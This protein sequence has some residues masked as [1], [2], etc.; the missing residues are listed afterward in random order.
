MAF[1]R[2]CKIGLLSLKS[3]NL[4]VCT[5]QSAMKNLSWSE[6]KHLMGVSVINCPVT[7]QV[8]RTSSAAFYPFMAFLQAYP[9]G[10]TCM[11]LQLQCPSIVSWVW[12]T[13]PSVTV[14]LW[15]GNCICLA[16]AFSSCL[17][18]GKHLRTI[19]AR[20]V[21]NTIVHSPPTCGQISQGAIQ[22][23]DSK[24]HGLM[25]RNW[26]SWCQARYLFNYA[27]GL[28]LALVT[29]RCLFTNSAIFL[30]FFSNTAAYDWEAHEKHLTDLG[31]N[32]S[33]IYE[34]DPNSADGLSPW[35]LQNQTAL[36][37]QHHG[38]VL[39]NDF[40]YSAPFLLVSRICRRIRQFLEGCISM[41]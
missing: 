23:G 37:E 41:A 15:M 5:V 21:Q 20:L 38:I 2:S 9:S 39:A 29:K 27:A 30:R 32:V 19:A 26:N 1:C 25:S 22:S 14:T 10:H 7:S 34:L 24:M 8:T 33:N 35:L 3:G 6:R 28:L 17:L 36:Y 40:D 4:H 12:H 16:V 18:D 13:I 11:G 31:H